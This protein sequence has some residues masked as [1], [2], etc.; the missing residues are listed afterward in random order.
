MP[1]TIIDSEIH[2]SVEATERSALIRSFKHLDQEH[3]IMVN[4]R[5]ST[6]VAAI[7]SEIHTVN[8]NI[9]NYVA[10]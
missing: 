8:S 3:C 7:E 1:R 9:I 4:D 2:P 5:S 6:K 10:P